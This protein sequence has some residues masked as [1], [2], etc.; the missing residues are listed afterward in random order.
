MPSIIMIIQTYF[1]KK[2]SKYQET[3]KTEQCRVYINVRNGTKF[4]DAED[5]GILGFLHSKCSFV[6]TNH[7]MFSL[8]RV[9]S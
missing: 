3:V 9:L 6:Y 2:N 8:V 5:Y 4:E 7:P 1:Q